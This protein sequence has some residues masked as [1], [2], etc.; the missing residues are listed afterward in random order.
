MSA[1][2]GLLLQAFLAFGLF[3][4]GLPAGV[5]QLGLLL[6]NLTIALESAT[7]R[8]WELGLKGY[9]NVAILA[10]DDLDALEQRF[11]A[12]ASAAEMRPAASAHLPARAGA[13]PV[14]G[15]FPSPP[16]SG[17]GSGGYGS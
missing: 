6:V 9:R 13:T 8:G 2:I 5:I 12:E 15:L 17:H 10:G 14:L 4:F 3:A 11:Y 16:H 7:I 1:L